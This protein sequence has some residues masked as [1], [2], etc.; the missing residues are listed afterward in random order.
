MIAATLLSSCS[1]LYS[2]I[3]GP[4]TSGNGSPETSSP[5]ETTRPASTTANKPS[6]TTEDP[7]E[8]E[9]PEPTET[10]KHP[11]TGVELLEDISTNRAIALVVNNSFLSMPQDGIGSADILCEF[12]C[13]DG[14]TTLLAI[15][16][17]AGDGARVGPLGTASKVM[18]DVAAGFDAVLFSANVSETVSK[19]N[20]SRK[21]Y[22]YEDEDFMYYG[23]FEDPYRKSSLGYRYCIMGEGARL[24]AAAKQSGAKETSGATFSSIFNFYEGET[25]FQIPNGKKA[26]NVYIPVSSMQHIQLV[27]SESEKQYYRYQYGTRIHTDALTGEAITFTNLFLLTAATDDSNAEDPDEIA[28]SAATRGSGYFVSHGKYV[29]INWVKGSDGAFRFYNT[30]GAQLQIP[31]GQS[32]MAFLS[33][34]QISS[35]Q[36]NH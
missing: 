34:S 23:F 22:Y 2:Y 36:Y 15:Y 19:M 30:A 16:K 14:S 11:L 8:T 17:D 27:Y 24:L 18:L 33:Q 1:Y 7:S 3:S 20:T 13:K 10:Y 32:Y 26:S 21:L 4:E 9:P 12:P 29:A 25:E 28:L 31:A 35:I 6:S 5:A